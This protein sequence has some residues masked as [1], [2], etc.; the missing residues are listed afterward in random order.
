MQHCMIKSLKKTRMGMDRYTKKIARRYLC[1][2]E[3]YESETGEL[4]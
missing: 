2:I 1:I 3:S 4:T